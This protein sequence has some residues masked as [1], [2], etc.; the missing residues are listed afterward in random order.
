MSTKTAAQKLM[1]KP[2]Q[3]VLFVGA[4]A[5]LDELL[6]PLPGN[7]TI[8]DDNHEPA[9]VTVAFVKNRQ[10]LEVQLPRLKEKF[11]P[12]G[13][14]WIA[15]YK[16]TARVK[17]DIH[18]DII[19]DFAKSIGLEGIFMISINEDWSALRLKQR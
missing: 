5:N 16:Q 19:N 13:M 4:P 3:K 12:G 6:G 2:G 17:T 18:R 11:K 10:E 15:Y 8:V 9:D 1:I 14:L 7:I